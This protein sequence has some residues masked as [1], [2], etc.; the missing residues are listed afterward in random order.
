M[1]AGAAYNGSH[2][3][4]AS[5]YSDLSNMTIPNDPQELYRIC[6]FL[7]VFSPVHKAYARNMATLPATEPIIKTEYVNTRRRD[8]ARAENDDSFAVPQDVVT[9]RIK[10]LVDETLHLKRFN[11]EA[12]VSYWTYSSTVVLIYFPFIKMLKCPKCRKS[13]RADEVDWMLRES[14]VFEGACGHCDHKGGMVATDRHIRSE[15]DIEVVC[16]DMKQIHTMKAGY[17]NR[18]DVY[19]EIPKEDIDRLRSQEEADREFVLRTPQAYIESALG[20]SRYGNRF[21]SKPVVK[22]RRD[23][24]YLMRSAH[25]PIGN[26]GL[27]IPGFLASL[28]DYFQLRQLQR[29]S[30]AISNESIIPLDI[31]YPES[32]S[33]SGNVFEMISVASFMDVIRTEL[34]KW[35]ED[36]GYKP[37]LPFPTATSRVGGDGKAL[38]L[39]S[40]IR[41][42]MEILCAALECPIEFIFGGLSYSGSDVSIQQMIKKLDDY[43]SDLLAMNR[44]VIRRISETMGWPPSVIE[45]EDFRLGQDLPYTQMISSLNQTYKVSDRRLH[46]LLK[47]DTASE[48]EEILDDLKHE[49]RMNQSRMKLDARAQQEIMLRQAMADAEGQ[50]LGKGTMLEESLNL[51]DRV[52]SDPK[53]YAYVMASPLMA[54]EI[55]GPGAP[56]VVQMSQMASPDMQMMAPAPEKSAPSAAA[57]DTTDQAQEFVDPHAVTRLMGMVEPNADQDEDDP[58]QG[59]MLVDGIVSSFAELDPSQWLRG[60]GEVVQMYGPDVSQQVQSKLFQAQALLGQRSS[61]AKGQR[62]EELDY[63]TPF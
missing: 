15:E 1:G 23:H 62:R 46:R 51:A 21:E 37:V 20:N 29:A 19:Y 3:P 61:Y 6:N 28:K 57:E 27:P 31:L 55:F 50:V 4:S 11:Q 9:D 44:W 24:Y 48:R 60:M 25:L 54:A 63:G 35:K 2:V 45:F 26:H 16:L 5:P 59:G 47:I 38:L 42:Y 7:S 12:G 36:P 14:G 30:E 49:M 53:L 58:V 56:E 43:R 18:V 40:E 32:S 22:L 39:S 52:R 33:R 34:A 17:S 10:H 8:R 13:N 41:V